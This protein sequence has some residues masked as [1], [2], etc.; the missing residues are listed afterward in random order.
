MTGDQARRL[1]ILARWHRRVALIVFAWVAILAISGVLINHA[2]DWGLDRRPVAAS[3]QKLL[4][5][6]ERSAEN[7]C[8]S[9]TLPAADCSKLFARLALPEGELLLGGDA[10][11]L[12]DEDGVLIERIGV[13]QLGLGELRAGM[14]DGSII[15]LR[16]AARVVETDIAL[17]DWHVLEPAAAARLE[18]HR[19][20]SNGGVVA[21]ISW[22]R[23]LLDLHA[24]RFLGRLA[25]GFTDLMGLL[26][27]LLTLSGFWM[28]WL[29][30]KPA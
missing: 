23:L 10:L 15:Y 6:I 27:L 4:Y 30:R 2:N 13:S 9:Q 11:F 1:R 12:M 14:I 19:W 29:K 8:A 26:I 16:D 20:T 7:F 17:L 3:L 5:G 21:E 18:Q 25:S 28:W 22:E 24:G